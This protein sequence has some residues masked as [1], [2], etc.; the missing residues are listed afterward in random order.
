MCNPSL[1]A[2]P[3]PPSFSL[4]WPFPGDPLTCILSLKRSLNFPEIYTNKIT[5]Y[6]FSFG[7]L[8]FNMFILICTYKSS[9]HSF[10]S[11]SSISLYG[12]N[13][14]FICSSVDEHLHLLGLSFFFIDVV[15]HIN[16]WILSKIC[17]PVIQLT[18]PWCIIHLI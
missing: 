7:R 3:K 12:Y 14:V 9:V 13:T 8:S 17:I 11:L 5:Q 10:L 1:L 16:F 18:W 15:N 2:L 6:A 4:P